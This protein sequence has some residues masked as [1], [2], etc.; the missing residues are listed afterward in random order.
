MAFV[1]QATLPDHTKD[2]NIFQSC[3]VPLA[4][5]VCVKILEELGG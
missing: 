4:E 5:G 2:K 3:Q 1:D